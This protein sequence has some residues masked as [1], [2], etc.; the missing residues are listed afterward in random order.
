[1]LT[2]S[3]V[4]GPYLRKDGRKHVILRLTNGKLR[5]ISYPKWLLMQAGTVFKKDDTVDHE[6]ADFKNDDYINL[7]VLPRAINSSIAHNRIDKV[8]VK[9]IKCDC[10]LLRDARA[11]HHNAILG[12][13]GPFCKK[14]GGSYGAEVQ[15]GLTDKLPPQPQVP[16]S[17]RSYYKPV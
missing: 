15:N 10:V 16:V 12:K 3:K 17:E 14:C 2:Y 6:D 1:M 7:R 5:T 8:E 13:A 4:Y 9:C 11:L